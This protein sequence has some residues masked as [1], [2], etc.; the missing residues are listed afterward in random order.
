MWVIWSQSNDL[1][2]STASIASFPYSRESISYTL[3]S[4]LILTVPVKA[5]AQGA[6]FPRRV[7][8]STSTSIGLPWSASLV[9]SVGSKKK[10][11]LHSSW[12]IKQ[13]LFGAPIVAHVV[14]VGVILVIGWGFD[15]PPPLPSPPPKKIP[16]NNKKNNICMKDDRKKWEKKVKNM[17]L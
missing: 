15:P 2:F 17:K 8:Q 16:H 12:E 14:R 7:T 4:N 5:L 11:N 3:A 9:L 1:N 13:Y 6:S 10:F